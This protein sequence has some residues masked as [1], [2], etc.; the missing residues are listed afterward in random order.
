MLYKA[1]RLSH[2]W[3]ELQLQWHYQESAVTIVHVIQGC[4]CP[5]AF[6]Q[7]GEK[8]AAALAHYESA[9]QPELVQQGQ[10]PQQLLAALG[11]ADTHGWQPQNCAA[12]DE[13]FQVAYA[14]QAQCPFGFAYWSCRL[15][16]RHCP[17][18]SASCAVLMFC[19]PLPCLHCRVLPLP[20]AL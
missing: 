7:A 15:A 16:C 12:Y 19:G 10:E 4:N 2:C 8:A 3:L 11:P 13:D 18:C 6:G 20:V 9:P 1:H 17:V 5:E 14:L